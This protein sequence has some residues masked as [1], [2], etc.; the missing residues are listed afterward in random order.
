MSELAGTHDEIVNL[1]TSRILAAAIEGDEKLEELL[2]HYRGM[3][4]PPEVVTDALAFAYAAAKV[5]VERGTK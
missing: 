1:M 5:L 3:R 2:E 4:V